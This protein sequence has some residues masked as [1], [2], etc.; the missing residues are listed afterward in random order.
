MQRDVGTGLCQQLRM[1][2]GSVLHHFVGFERIAPA[3]AKRTEDVKRALD[4]SEESPDDDRVNG[5]NGPR[6]SSG[7]G[8]V[9]CLAQMRLVEVPAEDSL[10]HHD[11]ATRLGL[12]QKLPAAEYSVAEHRGGVL[13]H[14]DAHGVGAETAGRIGQQVEP[15]APARRRIDPV[16]QDDAE[17]DIRARARGPGRAR[18]K[19]VDCRDVGV[20]APAVP[21]AADA[22]IE[23]VGDWSLGEH[24]RILRWAAAEGN[25]KAWA[26]GAGGGS[27]GVSSR[28]QYPPP[29]PTPLHAERFAPLPSSR[30]CIWGK[31]GCWD[32]PYFATWI[33]IR[34]EE[35]RTD[36]A[37]F[38]L[39]YRPELRQPAGMVHGGALATL[40]DTAVVPAIGGAYDEMR[41]LVTV[42]MNVQYL[43]PVVEQDAIAEAWVERR[44]RST[45]FCRVEVRDETGSLAATG[46]LIYKVGSQP[47]PAVAGA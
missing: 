8:C 12:A 33:G 44:G 13:E 21:E 2:I 31:F 32:T 45:V 5:Q 41:T 20:V 36:Y 22:S 24:D 7:R 43:G 26:P 37:R 10:S 16:A 27:A 35:V 14:D 19:E 4:R 40:I 29:M 30:A 9:E 25:R 28:G 3:R 15:L 18:A 46:T 11:P 17:V 6:G 39:P 23:I 38:R 1:P 42:T 47:R 34:L